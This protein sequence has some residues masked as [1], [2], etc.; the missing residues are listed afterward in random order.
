MKFGVLLLLI[1]SIVIAACTT[2]DAASSSVCSGL[3]KEASCNRFANS[4]AACRW[5]GFNTSSGMCY[6]AA[7]GESCCLPPHQQNEGIYCTNYPS[8]C[9]SQ[10]TCVQYT[11]PTTFGTNCYL[12]KCCDG[13]NQDND[14]CL[15]KCI[16]NKKTQCC[17]SSDR[18]NATCDLPATCCGGYT[19][20]CCSAGFVC[21]T[22]REFG[23]PSCC[24]AVKGC[25]GN[26]G[27]NP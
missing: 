27:C 24:P 11:E 8:I 23:P 18:G 20:S 4:T 13:A 21:C 22:R 15:G 9:I 12:S 16:N 19:S 1:A 6:S 26:G 17:G 5:C 10:Q 2:A 25:N 3:T 14:V 7:A